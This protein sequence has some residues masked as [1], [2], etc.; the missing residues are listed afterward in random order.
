[1]VGSGGVTSLGASSASGISP[2][3][4]LTVTVAP[5]GLPVAPRGLAEVFQKLVRGGVHSIQCLEH[6][7]RIT[8]PTRV[9][10]SASLVTDIFLCDEA[11]DFFLLHGC[12]EP[13]LHQSGEA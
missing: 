9:G 7:E 2:A 11:V 13:S 6:Y 8:L 12:N 1:M 3:G 10:V 5:R 4:L